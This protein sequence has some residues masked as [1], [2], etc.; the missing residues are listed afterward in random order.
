MKIDALVAR[1]G[2]LFHNQLDKEIPVFWKFTSQTILHQKMPSGE[3]QM[4]FEV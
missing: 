1:I 3:F 4:A 2:R